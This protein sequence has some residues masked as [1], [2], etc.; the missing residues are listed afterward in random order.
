[1]VGLDR[2]SS[3]SFHTM[4]IQPAPPDSFRLTQ[5][6]G[7]PRGFVNWVE[8]FSVLL[9]RGYHE[10]VSCVRSSGVRGSRRLE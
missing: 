4:I 3:D 10:A 8:A 1:M 2:G 9:G 6:C 7:A 5:F